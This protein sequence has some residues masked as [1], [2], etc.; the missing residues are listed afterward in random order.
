MF[1]QKF[2]HICLIS[3]VLTQLT[4][5]KPSQ[6]IQDTSG[7]VITLFLHKKPA[8]KDIQNMVGLVLNYDNPLLVFSGSF[9]PFTVI[10]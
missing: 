5:E 6:E 9:M 10:I 7:V 1:K 2:R 3:G 4:P 8:L